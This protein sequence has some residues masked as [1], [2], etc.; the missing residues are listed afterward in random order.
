[1]F[2]NECE[3]RRSIHKTTNVILPHNSFSKMCFYWFESLLSVVQLT[4]AQTLVNKG[5]HR[6]QFRQISS[7]EDVK[8]EK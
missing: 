1:M 4:V 3:F 6:R 5:R 7:R 2:L 8:Q